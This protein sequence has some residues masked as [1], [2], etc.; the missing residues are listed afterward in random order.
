MIVKTYVQNFRNRLCQLQNSWPDLKPTLKN[1]TKFHFNMIL[2]ELNQFGC[3]RNETHWDIGLLHPVVDLQVFHST[4]PENPFNLWKTAEL[5]SVVVKYQDK[6]L[7]LNISLCD[8]GCCVETIFFSFV[9]Y[10]VKWHGSIEDP[11]VVPIQPTYSWVQGKHQ[12][13]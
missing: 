2:D 10:F 7:N 1:C 3:G 4:G 11:H 8:R 5:V 12:P 13:L 9:N 6:H